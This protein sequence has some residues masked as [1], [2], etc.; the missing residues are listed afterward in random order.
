MR[1]PDDH[2]DAIDA[3]LRDALEPDPGAVEKLVRRAMLSEEA[4]LRRRLLPAALAASLLA[5]AAV[6]LLRP[7]P[8][9]PAATITITNVGDV[10]VATSPAGPH[11]LIRSEPGAAAPAGSMLI[12]RRHEP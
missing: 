5:L 11:W 3:R 1:H 7:E 10:V 4:G 12:L 8:P 6:I 2:P 9:P